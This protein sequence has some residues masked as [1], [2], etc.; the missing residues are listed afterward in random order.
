MIIQTAISMHYP[1]IHHSPTVYP[2]PWSFIPERWLP[3]PLPKAPYKIPSRPAGIPQANPKYLV[4]FSKGTRNC[5]GYPLAYAELYLTIATVA[6]N[7]L[8]IER[9]DDDGGILGV[10][11]MKL[12]ETDRRDTDMKRDLGFPAPEKGRGNIRI[13]LE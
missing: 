12:F 9:D 10:K 7:F 1:L 6:R 4:P 5:I 13:V 11:G 3:S 2:E 8:S